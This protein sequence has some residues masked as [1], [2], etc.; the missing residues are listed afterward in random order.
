MNDSTKFGVTDFLACIGYGFAASFL[1][2]AVLW[3]TVPQVLAGGHTEGAGGLDN[4]IAGVMIVFFGGG[5]LF[6]LAAG[7]V[8]AVIKKRTGS[9]SSDDWWP[10]PPL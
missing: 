8:R 3:L 6:S 4:L 7:W 2:A 5:I 1:L 10:P 9:N